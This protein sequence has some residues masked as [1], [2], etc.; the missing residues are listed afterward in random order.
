MSAQPKVI[1]FEE[2]FT[3]P[4]RR[5]RL[6]L[7]P[8]CPARSRRWGSS[9]FFSVAWPFMPNLAGR[10]WVGAAPIDDPDRAL[11]FGANARKLLKL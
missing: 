2:H 10:Q 5:A 1:A 9:K 11:I 3:S 4:K 6:Y 8:H 7:M